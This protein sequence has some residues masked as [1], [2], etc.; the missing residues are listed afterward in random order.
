[1]SQQVNLK[2]EMSDYIHPDEDLQWIGHNGLKLNH[3]E[4]YAINFENG[5]KSKAQNGGSKKT[6]S[7]VSTLSIFNP[8]VQDSGTY[9]CTLKGTPKMLNFS[10]LV[11]PT[12]TSKCF[13]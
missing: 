3:S 1:M 5:V 12:N 8:T 11:M 7:R 4:K 13:Q 6:F 10:L 2:C 9:S